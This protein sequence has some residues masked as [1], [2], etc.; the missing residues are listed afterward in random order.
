VRVRGGAGGAGGFRFA[1][2]GAHLQHR[3]GAHQTTYGQSRMRQRARLNRRQSAY[4]GHRLRVGALSHLRHGHRGGAPY[5]LGGK[6]PPWYVPPV[7]SY[8]VA[9]NV[10]GDTTAGNWE[11]T[12]QLYAP[13]VRE[14]E[15]GVV[16]GSGRGGGGYGLRGRGLGVYRRGGCALSVE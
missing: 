9:G 1:E 5:M 12:K 14:V 11:A 8:D 10:M 3:A 2:I 16:C 4:S 15:S 7:G 13:K 6:D